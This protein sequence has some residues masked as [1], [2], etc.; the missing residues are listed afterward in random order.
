MPV[1]NRF[2]TI[3]FFLILSFVI[4][5]AQQPRLILPIGHTSYVTSAKFSPDEKY[6]VTASLDNTVKIWETTTGKLVSKLQGRSSKIYSA[7][8][9]PDGK[10]VAILEDTMAR[11][12]ET[13]SGK[14]V[15]NLQGQHFFGSG[16][17]NFSQD[18]KYVLTILSI[19]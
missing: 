10:Y 16:S 15:S 7:E 17:I 18:G 9:S 14:L 11:I 6:V 3:L 13:S 12:W 8:F 4:A 1:I 2:V 5:K 19:Q